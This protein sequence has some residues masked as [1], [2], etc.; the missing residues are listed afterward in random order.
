MSNPLPIAENA[1]NR[2]KAG[3]YEHDPHDW[4]VEEPWCADVLLDAVD[5]EGTILDPACGGGRIVETCRRRGFDA[6]GSDLIDRG[7]AHC[8]PRIDFT[9]PGAWA[10]GSFDNIISN[11]PYYSGKGPVAFIDAGLA[12]ARRRVAA[13]VALPFLAGQ[14]RNPWFRALPVSHVLVLSRRPSMPPGHLLGSV[15]Q[16]GGKEDYVWIVLTHGHTGRPV[17]DWLLP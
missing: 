1:I 14:R 6:V 3:G 2:H 17:F 10:P 16:K 11:P 4:Y 8:T 13:L 9:L 5:F 7:Y 12:V 15:A